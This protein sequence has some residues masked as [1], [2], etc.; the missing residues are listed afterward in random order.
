VAKGFV[1]KTAG[2]ANTSD[3]PAAPDRGDERCGATSRRRSAWPLPLAVAI[4]A[5]SLA[6]AFAAPSLAASPAWE[7]TAIHGPTN[8][9]RTPSANQVMTL[10][11]KAS[12]GH[13][14]LVFENEETEEEVETKNLHFDATAAEVQA[15]LEEKKAIG[16]GNVQVSGGPGDE[17]G[18]KPYVIEFTGALGNRYL[19]SEALTVEEELEPTAIEEKQFEKE[20]PEEELPEGTAAVRLTTAGFHETVVYQLIPRDLGA[21]PAGGPGNAITV[22]DKLPADLATK[23]LPTGIGWTCESLGTKA[24]KT[25]EKKANKEAK[26]PEGAG[27]TEVRC[28]S[29]TA[30]NPDSNA[31]S[32][33]I[34]AYVNTSALIEGQQLENQ[35]RVSGGGVSA[36]SLVNCTNPLKSE[37]A[38]S[39]TA[40]CKETAT[41]SSMP[42]SFGIQ[43]F[44]ASSFGLNG[45]KYTQAGGHPYAA[46]SGFF[47]DTVQR[48]NSDDGSVEVAL[49]D[50]VKDADVKVPAGFIG[51]PQSTRRCTQAEFT[52]GLK[53]APLE[54]KGSCPPESQVGVA[55]VYLKEFGRAPEPVAVYNLL[56]PAGLPA[57]FGFIFKQVP[58][59]LDAHVVREAGQ[60]GEYRLT[61]LSA[62]INEAYNVFG[63]EVTLWGIPQ[64]SSHTPERFKNASPFEKGAEDPEPE[65]PFLTS[66]V[67]CLGEASAPPITTIAYDRWQRPGQTDGHG[68]PVLSDPR[69]QIAEALAPTVTN[70]GL[71]DLRFEPTIGFAPAT[72]QADAPAGFTFN[73]SVPQNEAPT[74]LVTPEL[75]DTTVTLPEGVTLSPSAANGLQACSDG[76]IDL[77]STDRGSCPDASQVG[78]V[79]IKS[80]LLDAPLTGRVYIGEPQCSPCSPQDAE[81]GKLFRLFIE[82][83]GSGVRVKLPGTAS[84]NT[85]TGRLT[86]TFRNNPQL[87]FENLELVLKSGPR[88]PLANPQACGTYTTTTDLTP[89]SRGGTTPGGA[90][91]AGTPDA[92]PSFSFGVDWDGAGAACPGSLPFNPGFSAGTDN[93]QAGAYSLFDVTFTRNDREQDLSGTT[94]RTP[95]GLLGKIA[96]IPR[97]SEQ[98]ANAGSCPA[99]ARIATA[100]SAAGA[101]ANPFVVSG[102]VYLTNGYK[103]A[104]FGLS[105]VVPAVAGPFNL[106]TVIVRAAISVSPQTS[107]LTIT[108]DPLPQS[109]DGVPFRLKTVKVMVDRPQ[110]MFNATNCEAKS[111][112]ATLTGAPAGAGEAPV[113]SGLSAPYTASGCASLPFKPT[114]TARTEARTSKLEGASLRVRVVQPP[115]S[116]NIRKV[117]VRLPIALPSRLTTLQKACTEAQFNSNPAG[118]PEGS[119]VGTATAITPLLSVPLAGPA[120]LVSHG[121]AGFPDLVFLLQGEG[122][123]IELVGH[124]DIKKGITISTFEAVPDAPISSFE[125]VLPRGPHSILTGNGN[126][127]TQSLVAPTKITAQNNA[128][129]VQQTPVTVSGCAPSKPSV[130]IVR[131]KVKGNALMLTVK[132]SGKGNVKISGAGLKTTTKRGLAAGTHQIK[133]PLSKAGKAAKRKHKKLKLRASLT[134]GS[135][136][137]N[138]T[139]TVK[140]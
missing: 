15:A 34:E 53:G 38:E 26:L 110:F 81:D 89:W 103:G 127:C 115:G 43:A 68:D 134:V 39:A 78:T 120:Y 19:G 123:H 69:W 73:L 136:S 52:S 66:P 77:E 42:A 74:G 95:P 29:E 24:E 48:T 126:L 14:A 44:T 108:S 121:N 37:L 84:A 114:F 118:C 47:F 41:V 97:C 87:P 30:V 90:P 11:I 122:I 86:T 140:A 88:A 129:V 71:P 94:V 2:T 106:G 5:V 31:S 57:E 35:A 117:E 93:S 20:H 40:P 102:P 17:T 76:A 116:A 4:A 62:D 12:L 111:I 128:L 61:V 139:A 133:V 16:A 124:T 23:A 27:L 25:A 59:R 138:K 113:T 130:S 98:D 56:P 101:G 99:A 100:T 109:I 46:T 28:T 13:F 33:E 132:T 64:E 7:L 8:V 85:T 10:T 32:I 9:P 79:T 135:Q 91:I 119:V 131:S 75:K 82:A 104:P 21:A 18:T 105:I 51:N 80:Q 3:P 107:A 1:E 137:V 60:Q 92:T 54:G 63:V 83:E 72:T 67:D 112:G 125:T 50:R 45:E 70:C 65:R 22:I 96:G 49:P 58:V 55:S 6:L 36:G